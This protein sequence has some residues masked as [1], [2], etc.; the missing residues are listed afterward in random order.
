MDVKSVQVTYEKKD[1]GEVDHCSGRTLEGDERRHQGSNLSPFLLDMVTD[2]LTVTYRVRMVS[3]ILM[4]ADDT[5][6]CS[7]KREQVEYALERR[8][9]KVSYSKTEY[10]C[11]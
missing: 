3:F 6:I 11:E 5:V 8:G 2:R 7:E 4:L 1:S 10:T 9:T